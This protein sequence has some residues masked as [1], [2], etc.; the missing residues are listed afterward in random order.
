MIKDGNQNS[1][2]DT[3]SKGSISKKIIILLAL[4]IVA[5]VAFKYFTSNK[6][7]A[8]KLSQDLI[9]NSSDEIFEV[10]DEDKKQDYDLSDLTIN[11]MRERGAEFIY[12]ILL[13]NQVQIE[14]SR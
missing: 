13:K 11:D 9:L 6:K 12:Q 3:K 5:F 14:K 2:A 7:D 1:A 4:S 8:P 10:S